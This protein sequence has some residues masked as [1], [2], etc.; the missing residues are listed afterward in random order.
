MIAVK[1]FQKLKL[2]STTNTTVNLTFGSTYG[3]FPYAPV[4]VDSYEVDNKAFL[5]VSKAYSQVL[6]L[7]SRITVPAT[8]LDRPRVQVIRRGSHLSEIGEYDPQS[9]NVRHTP[10]VSVTHRRRRSVGK[11]NRRHDDRRKTLRPQFRRQWN[12]RQKGAGDPADRQCD[13]HGDQE[14]V[15]TADKDGWFLPC[16]GQVNLSFVFVSILSL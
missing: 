6:P 15:K 4:S 13:Q 7:C 14:P 3:N 10:K 5:S 8:A 2:N 11:N 9:K 16:L 1:S 12:E